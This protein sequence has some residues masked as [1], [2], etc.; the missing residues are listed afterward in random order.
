MAFSTIRLIALE[1]PTG[2]RENIT[3]GVSMNP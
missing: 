1:T 3:R 2:C